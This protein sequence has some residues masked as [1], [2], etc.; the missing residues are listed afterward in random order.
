S[1]ERDR[2]G[3]EEGRERRGEE[4]RGEEGRGERHRHFVSSQRQPASI[5]PVSDV[6]CHC[7]AP[8]YLHAKPIFYLGTRLRL[9]KCYCD[10]LPYVV[11]IPTPLLSLSHTHTHTHRHTICG[12][13]PSLS[14]LTGRFSGKAHMIS[15]E[16]MQHHQQTLHRDR[17][18]TSHTH[19]HTHHSL[20]HNDI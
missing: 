12:K 20:L 10:W 16:C 19:T 17:Q 7:S 8:R 3:W 9:S 6:C 4:R 5:R 14:S 11:F 18:T 15:S 1:R 2:G 13:P